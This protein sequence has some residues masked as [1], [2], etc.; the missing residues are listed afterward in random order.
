MDTGNTED[1]SDNGYTDGTEDTGGDEIDYTDGGDTD[2]GGDGLDGLQDG[3]WEIA[4]D[5]E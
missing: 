5:G 3:S 2:G 1:G 4:G